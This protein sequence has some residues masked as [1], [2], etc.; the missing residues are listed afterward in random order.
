MSRS[1]AKRRI[2]AGFDVA[3]GREAQDHLLGARAGHHALQDAVEDEALGHVVV[4]LLHQAVAFAAVLHH[5]LRLELVEGR[6]GQ[7]LEHDVLR[8][9]QSNDV[10]LAVLGDRGPLRRVRF[11]IIDHGQS[12][13]QARETMM[14]FSHSFGVE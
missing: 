14:I 13:R 6:L 9:L 3:L 7:Q 5:Q 4:A 12:R 11:Q 1:A 8:Q 2:I 10:A